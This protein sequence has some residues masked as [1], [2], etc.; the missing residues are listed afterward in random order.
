MARFTIRLDED[1]RAALVELAR[2]ERRDPRDQAALL[3]RDEL[4]RRGILKFREGHPD[5]RQ[6]QSCIAT[7]S[8][9][10]M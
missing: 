9:Q 3:V 7:V 1:E 8:N 10:Q 5:D 2:T 6:L 4:T